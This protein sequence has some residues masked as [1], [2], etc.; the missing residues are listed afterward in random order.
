[1]EKGKSV[2]YQNIIENLSD[3]VLVIDPDNR[4]STCNPAACTLLGLDKESLT[5]AGLR[6]LMKLSAGNDKFFEMLMDAA[7]L[8]R[9][10]SRTV[11]YR[12][13]RSMKHFK[14]TTT[15]ME[16][17]AG[18]NS[19]IVL[20][21]DHT[22][23]T[24]LI[25]KNK[26]L[27]TQITALMNS[28]VEVMVTAFE[29]KSTYNA[30]HTK[31][32][33]KYAQYYLEWLSSH[34]ELSKK[35]SKNTEPLLMSFWLHDIGKL[36]VSQEIMDKAT[37]LGT[38]LPNILNKLVI[39]RL[40]IKIRMLSGDM[41]EKK[42]EKQLSRLDKAEKL[43]IEANTAQYLDDKTVAKLTKVASFKILNADGETCPLLDPEELEEITIQRGTLTQEEREIIESHAELTR[44]LLSKMEFVGSFKNVPTWASEHHEYL[45][46][47]GY[48]DKLKAEDIPWEVRLLTVIDIYDALIADDRPYK[49]PVTPEKAFGILREMAKEGKLDGDIIESFYIS[50]AWQTIPR[51]IDIREL[52]IEAAKEN[53]P[54]VINFIDSYLDE[55]GCPK[56]KKLQI[57]LAVEE[58]F[59]NIAF[60]AYAPDTGDVVV[61]I[62]RSKDNSQ[63]VVRLIDW[64]I[65]YNPLTKE[66]PDISLSGDE[67]QIG[68]LGIF[69][70]KKYTDD[71]RYKFVDGRNR[72]TI[73]KNLT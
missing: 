27:T 19:L 30:N 55:I 35:T 32:M 43:I 18:E 36:L 17:K 65:P 6:D 69:L 28:F 38:A 62:G 21:S 4:I 50:N 57:D 11:A 63:A 59:V 37:R 9:N 66:D 60:Y 46:G 68:G 16:Q 48:P 67:R 64:G 7:C 72:I 58:L 53:L 2:L 5:G 12:S 49:P 26:S 56:A 15:V 47:T 41:P 44:K 52:R 14:I 34:G 29:E 13:G 25:V 22:E 45:D 31:N 20:I 71:V 10:L 54:E 33:V 8:S 39:A 42:A 23:V 70:I 1:M 3:G 51:C 24:N 61:K 40:M 73:V